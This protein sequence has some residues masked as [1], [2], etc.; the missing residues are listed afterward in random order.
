MADLQM[1]GLEY[2]HTGLATTRATIKSRPDLVRNVMRAYIEGIHYYK[3]HRAESLAILAKYLKT[4]DTQVLTE[5]YEDIGL[6]LTAMKPY[7]TLRGI[8]IML[9]ELAGS[10]PKAATARPED[11]VDLSFVK[12]L[13]ASGFIDALYKASPVVAQR[14]EPPPSE[15]A[16]RKEKSTTE[17]ETVRNTVPAKGSAEPMREHTVVP[18]DTLSHLA[19]MYYGNSHKWPTIFAANKSTMKNPHYLYVGQKIFIPS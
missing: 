19:V 10:Q 4:N 9:R 8:E 13:D 18:G 5:I 7:P 12:E 1:L 2:Q 16:A 3:T 15:L 6:R 17:K 14:A 11:F